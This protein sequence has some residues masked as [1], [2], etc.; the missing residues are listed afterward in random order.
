MK[1]ITSWLKINRSLGAAIL[2]TAFFVALVALGTSS[3]R[4]NARQAASRQLG[5]ISAPAC[6]AS[7]IFTGSFTQGQ[8]TDPALAQ[9]WRDFRHNLVPGNYD[10]VTIRG[11]FDS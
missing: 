3:N 5:R 7:A 6:T 4:I 1:L 10:T 8:G 9:Q 2:S 11:T